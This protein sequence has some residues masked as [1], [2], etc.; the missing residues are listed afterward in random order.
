[1]DSKWKDV[2]PKLGRCQKGSKAQ[3]MD[4]KVLGKKAEEMDGPHPYT[5]LCSCILGRRPGGPDGT[6]LAILAHILAHPLTH[7]RSHAHSDLRLSLTLSQ[8]VTRRTGAVYSCT[9]HEAEGRYRH[10]TAKSSDPCL[11]G[12]RDDVV[13]IFTE[14]QT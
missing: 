14:P 12:T 2:N 5:K 6:Q 8:P 11:D 10:H 3:Q 13:I 9:R 4:N 1:L 7:H